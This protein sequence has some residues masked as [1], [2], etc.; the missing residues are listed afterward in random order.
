MMRVPVFRIPALARAART[1]LAQARRD[2]YQQLDEDALKEAFANLAGESVPR[3]PTEFQTAVASKLKLSSTATA[4]AAGKSAPLTASPREAF[5][6]YVRVNLL[7][8][9][10]AKAARQAWARQAGAGAHAPQC[11]WEVRRHPQA[12]RQRRACAY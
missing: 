3:A 4:T 2:G 12:P 5:P 8:T 9:S 1:L 11:A 10:V 7:K 6:R